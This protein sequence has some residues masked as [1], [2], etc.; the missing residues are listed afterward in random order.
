MKWPS[1]PR[2]QI[3][4]KILVSISGRVFE[5]LLHHANIIFI[6]CLLTL[7]LGFYI[8]ILKLIYDYRC[9]MSGATGLRSLGDGAGSAT[10]P[11]E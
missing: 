6:F 4:A 9:A 3:Q 1:G 5:S 11:I 8:P 7:L 10:P 2:R